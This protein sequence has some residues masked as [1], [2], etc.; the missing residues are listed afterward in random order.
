MGLSVPEYDVLDFRLRLSQKIA[1]G[2][3]AWEMS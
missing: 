2:V 1:L 3:G